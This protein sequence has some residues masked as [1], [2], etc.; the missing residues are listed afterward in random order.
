[1]RDLNS[2]AVEKNRTESARQWGSVTLR[3][4]GQWDSMTVDSEMEEGSEEWCSEA[5]GAVKQWEKGAV[6]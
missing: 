4:V 2:E 3:A 6:R 5:I 1:M